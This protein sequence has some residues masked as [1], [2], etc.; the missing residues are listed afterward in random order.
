[1][2][3][4]FRKYR[5]WIRYTYNNQTYLDPVEMEVALIPLLVQTL[6]WLN[7]GGGREIIE[8]R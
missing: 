3:L 6:A 8:G 5:W 7:K 4:L 2:E 1:M